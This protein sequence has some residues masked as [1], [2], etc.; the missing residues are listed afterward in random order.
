MKRGMKKVACLLIV[1]LMLCNVVIVCGALGRAGNRV[2]SGLPA[3]LNA[4]LQ[5]NAGYEVVSSM[6]LYH[7]DDTVIAEYYELSPEGYAI[8]AN[9]GTMVEYSL[10]GSRPMP[11]NEKVYYGG[12]L[13]Y[14]SRTEDNQYVDVCSGEVC[15]SSDMERMCVQYS[16]TAITTSPAPAYAVM[17]DD[18][19]PS[20]LDWEDDEIPYYPATYAHSGDT[21]GCGYNAICGTVA[22]AILLK[23]YNDHICPGI[24]PTWIPDPE[25]KPANF[26]HYLIAYIQTNGPYVGTYAADIADGLNVFLDHHDDNHEF[27]NYVATWESFTFAKL[28][29]LI[30][31]DRPCTL[32]INNHPTYGNHHVVAYGWSITYED[33]VATTRY[34]IVADGWGHVI[35][36]I[37]TDYIRAMA[38]FTE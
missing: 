5:Q 17:S 27:T 32:L 8:V 26:I 16:T 35:V 22:A 9:T 13:S 19:E 15:T 7:T 12:P 30:T 25:T 23:Y 29:Q 10:Q 6:P 24:V 33:F 28:Q 11:E 1:M 20:V 14:F 31:A 38:Y 2:S 18:D 3:S 37:N 36:Y 34:A 4:V 21:C